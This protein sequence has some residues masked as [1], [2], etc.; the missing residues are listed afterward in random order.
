MT[1]FKL[2]LRPLPIIRLIDEKKRPKDEKDE[3]MKSKK[4]KKE[5]KK[6]EKLKKLPNFG[7]RTHLKLFR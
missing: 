1:N 4:V 7:K 2:L 5:R 6:T 3:T